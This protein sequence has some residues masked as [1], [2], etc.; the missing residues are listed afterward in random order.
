MKK[1][2]TLL[3]FV[4]LIVVLVACQEKKTYRI[5]LVTDVGTVTDKSFNQGAW[6]GV[7]E[8][9]EE[10][11][12]SHQYL[13][14]SDQTTEE[15]V[16]SIDQAVK[17]GAEIIV[18]PG[19]FFENAV[20]LSQTKHPEVKF[21]ILDGAPHNIKNWD[22]GET[23][24][25]AN[26]FTNPE[27]GA[28]NQEDNVLSIMYAEHESGFLAG[29]AAVKDGMTK[30]G[31]MGGKA[32]PAV[33]KFGYGF[34][35][36]ANYAATE[37]GLA[38]DAIEMKF[39]YLGGFGPDP[40]FQAK[41]ASWYDGGTEVIFA[42]AGGAGGSVF[43]AAFQ[44]G[45]LAI[46]V[47]KDQREESTTIITSAMKELAPSVYDALVMWH[48]DE[49]PGG[50]QLVFDAANS[51]VKLADEF[52]RFDTFT[53]AMYDTIFAKL[54]DGTVVVDGAYEATDTPAVFAANYAKI[55]I[56]VEE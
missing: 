19:Y 23:L 26:F 10:Y 44:E 42:A 9:V 21:V 4:A 47:D 5:A 25:G 49:F 31:F 56:I 24:D 46:G 1:V 3:F 14:P 27:T 11:D 51:G 38:D 36:G 53:K 52:D 7:L 55:T 41:A 43:A 37:M 6:E 45:G 16:K 20:W 13:Q 33:T 48:E 35:Q 15:Y 17:D 28:F 18:T 34:I 39:T 54:V 8:F 32:V 40:V 22:T 50:E 12:I 30:L 2:V 29:Y